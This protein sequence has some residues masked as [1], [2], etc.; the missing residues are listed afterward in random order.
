MSSAYLRS[1]YVEHAWLTSC[2]TL[3]KLSAEFP[4]HPL[5]TDYQQK[6][7]LFDKLSAKFTVPPLATVSA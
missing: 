2:G 4:D 7:T 1:A 6:E 3:S 5:V